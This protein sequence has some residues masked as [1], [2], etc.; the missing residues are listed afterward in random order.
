MLPA[1][2]RTKPPLPAWIERQ[3]R[4]FAHRC[5]WNNH[6]ITLPFWTIY[7]PACCGR[8]CVTNGG[9]LDRFTVC[10]FYAVATSTLYYKKK[11]SLFSSARICLSGVHCILLQ[12]PHRFLPASE[13]VLPL[14]T[15]PV[16]A[17]VFVAGASAFS[18]SSRGD[19]S[20]CAAALGLPRTGSSLD[21][22]LLSAPVLAIGR[23]EKYA[24][25]AWMN[26]VLAVTPVAGRFSSYRHYVGRWFCR[27]KIRDGTNT[28]LPL[29]DSD[30]LTLPYAARHANADSFALAGGTGSDVYVVGVATFGVTRGGIVLR[31]TAHRRC[32]LQAAYIIGKTAMLAAYVLNS[33]L[34]Y[35]V[36]RINNLP[37]NAVAN[38][39]DVPLPCT[40]HVRCILWQWLSRSG[41]AVTWLRWDNCSPSG[42][43]RWM[44]DGTV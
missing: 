37:A 22:V 13:R 7:L 3:Q 9:Q 6:Y 23:K 14:L 31:F 26:V 5:A 11:P 15:P 32:T 1:G 38:T 18:I 17:R 10:G 21:I 27:L 2:Q 44:D 12:A 33:I 39:H 28:C 8:A 41:V 42:A 30:T 20:N 29:G 24:C 34:P 35:R 4:L 36:S 25:T 19:S 40:P 16:R 43:G